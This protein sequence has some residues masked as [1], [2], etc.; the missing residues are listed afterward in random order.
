MYIYYS[1][2]R[3]R[4]R[5]LD[6][7]KLQDHD[8]L[9]NQNKPKRCIN[10]DLRGCRK[11]DPVSGVEIPLL[12]LSDSS[13]ICKNC[14]ERQAVDKWFRRLQDTEIPTVLPQFRKLKGRECGN[15]KA[16]YRSNPE[17]PPSHEDCWQFYGIVGRY[18]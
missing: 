2:S 10:F 7:Y 6:D 4:R 5:Y 18:T 1:R 16:F 13:Y 17:L 9:P 12:Y 11:N 8:T 15:P 3:D 14:K